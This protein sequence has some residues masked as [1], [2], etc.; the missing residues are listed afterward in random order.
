MKSI[1]VDD[2]EQLEMASRPTLRALLTMG[3]TFPTAIITLATIVYAHVLNAQ[4]PQGDT[5]QTW[6]CR[7]QSDVTMQSTPQSSFSNNASFSSLC[8]E[9]KFAL[10]GTLVV[11]ILEVLSFGVAIGGWIA[12]KL[13]ERKQKKAYRDGIDSLEMGSREGKEGFV[14][15]QAVPPYQ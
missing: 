4:A 6:T 13:A 5:I 11:F 10:Y 9:S 14:N 12:E 3:I 15:V 2:N 7:L 1:D 8:G